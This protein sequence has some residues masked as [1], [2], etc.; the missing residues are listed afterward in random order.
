MGRLDA[1]FKIIAHKNACG[2]EEQQVAK[3]IALNNVVKSY[4][5]TQSHAVTGNWT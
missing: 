5:H 1:S 3:M 4:R 2:C